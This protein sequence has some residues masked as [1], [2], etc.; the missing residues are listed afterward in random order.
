MDSQVGK[1]PTI[2]FNVRFLQSGNK[3]AVAQAIFSG[4]GVDSRDP[5]GAEYPLLRATIAESILA[6]LSDRL[7]GDSKDTATRTIITFGLFED[8][9][10]TPTGHYAACYSGHDFSADFAVRFRLNFF[11]H[12]LHCWHISRMDL[13]SATQLTLALSRLLGQDVVLIHALSLESRTGFL[14]PLCGPA[15]RFQL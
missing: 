10:V 5:K 9:F 1:D 11:Q 3:L 8:F 4:L 14:E 12:S 15:V 6:C 2:N 7:L 13:S